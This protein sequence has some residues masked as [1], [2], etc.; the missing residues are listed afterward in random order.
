ATMAGT[1]GAEDN[2]PVS[3]VSAYD[4][5][6]DLQPATADPTD[7]A[8]AQ[9]VAIGTEGEGTEVVLVVWDLDESSVGNTY[10][11]HVHTGACV[12]GSPATA[13][14]H[15]NSGGPPDAE[16]EV[17]LDF[18][19]LPGGVGFAEASVPFVIPE[20]GAQSVVIHRLPTD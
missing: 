14:P 6:T 10:G 18:T 5:L 13:G 1:A 19:V 7:G 20:G 8:S 15:Y 16:H 2:G 3:L 12:E 11:A 4:A 9:V 17:W